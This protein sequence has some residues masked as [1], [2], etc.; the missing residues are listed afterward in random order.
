MTAKQDTIE[1]LEQKRAEL[2][3]KFAEEFYTKYQ[4]L[5]KEHGYQIVASPRYIIN[6]EGV[7]ATAIEYSVG[8]SGN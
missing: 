5:V 3:Q 2:E 6:A 7:F 8:K 1:Q 4:A